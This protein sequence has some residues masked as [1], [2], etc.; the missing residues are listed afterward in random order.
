MVAEHTS[1]FSTRSEA[2]EEELEDRPYQTVPDMIGRIMRRI[3]RF[4]IHSLHPRL[5][6]CNVQLIQ[7]LQKSLQ[8]MTA[9]QVGSSTPMLLKNGVI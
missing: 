9:L 8:A 4:G 5:Q 1:R 7:S 6:R 3:R 2:A